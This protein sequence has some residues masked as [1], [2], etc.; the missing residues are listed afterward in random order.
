[1]GGGIT[2]MHLGLLTASASMLVAHFEIIQ[3][4]PPMVIVAVSMALCVLLQAALAG[5]SSEAKV[6]FPATE[7]PTPPSRDNPRTA[8]PVYDLADEKKSFMAVCDKLIE[9]NVSELPNVCELPER[10][11]KWVQDCLNFNVKGGKM[12]RGLMV[13]ASGAEILKK[14]GRPVDSDTLTKLAVLGWCIEWLQ[15][16]LLVAD[17]FMDDSQTRRGQLCWYKHEHVQKIA[18]NDAFMIEMLVFRTLKRHFWT[19]PY[20]AQ[21]VDLFLETTFQTECGQ[22]LDL[23]CMNISLNDFSLDRWTLIV[24]YKTAFYSFYCPVALGMIVAGIDDREA[25]N[26]ARKPL[27]HM[28]VYFQAQDDYLDAFASPEQL[29]K[30]GTDIQDKKCGWLFC[31]AFNNLCSPEQ[32]KYLEDHYGKCKVDSTEE[33]AIRKMYKDL[34]LEDFYSKYEQQSYDEIMAMRPDVEKANLPWSV[35]ELFLK[36]VYKRSK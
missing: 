2:A 3:A 16:W 10:E 29:G 28:G 23:L 14:E 36:K 22:L 17:D 25:F 6:A 19:E 4:L 15:A 13:V 12:N 26:A 21:L 32:K 7:W 34:G 24:K 20:Y 11:V 5:S 30:I 18:I 31:H 9:E 8:Y 35:F 27:V 33:L 1:M